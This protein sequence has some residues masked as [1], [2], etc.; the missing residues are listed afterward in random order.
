MLEY[1]KISTKSPMDTE[2]AKKEVQPIAT[3][4]QT[5][6][7]NDQKLGDQKEDVQN[8]REEGQPP[9]KKMKLDDCPDLSKI[10]MTNELAVNH[11]LK[12]YRSHLAA[13]HVDQRRLPDQFIVD[14]GKLTEAS[15]SFVKKFG[16]H[17]KELQEEVG[18]DPSPIQSMDDNGKR[19][20]VDYIAANQTQFARRKQQQEEKEKALQ[21]EIDR[22]NAK[23][24]AFEEVKTTPKHKMN[25]TYTRTIE[26]GYLSQFHGY[27]APVNQ[28]NSSIE[29]DNTDYLCMLNQ[30][31]ADRGIC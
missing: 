1:H 28:K 4:Q 14:H 15:M 22:L 26:S 25:E 5:N 13:S 12:I 29:L 3:T 23:S 11:A 10:D 8:M 20:M 7:T 6:T 18:Y 17:L 27:S 16:N 9:F 30:S 24:V 2:Q 21:A 31:L 19:I